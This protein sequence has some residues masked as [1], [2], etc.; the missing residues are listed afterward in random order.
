MNEN[1]QLAVSVFQLREN[2][3]DV[4]V[5]GNVAHK[6]LG[7]GKRKDEIFGF[8]FETLVLVGDGQ[9]CSGGMQTLCDGPGDAAFI[10]DSE[11]DGHAAFEAERHQYPP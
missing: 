10:G 2:A 1:V 4:I 7:A 9:F 11:D 3:G 8:L 5:L 6:S